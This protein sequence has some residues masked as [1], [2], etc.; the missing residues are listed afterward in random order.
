MS[1]REYERYDDRQSDY[2]RRGGR[3][4]RDT[5][6][7]DYRQ[8][9]YDGPGPSQRTQTQVKERESDTIITQGNRTERGPRQPDFL[10]EDYGRNDNA[11][12]LVV[13]DDRREEDYVSRSGGRS[14]GPPQGERVEREE[15]VYRERDRSRGPPQPPYPR[16]EVGDD[17]IVFRERARSRPPPAREEIDISIREKETDRRPPPP[18]VY[19]PPPEQL[20]KKEEVTYTRERSRSRQPPPPRRD[21]EEIDIDIKERDSYNRG[22]DVRREDI[23]IDIKEQD[24]SRGREVRKEDID[25]DIDIRNRGGPAPRPRSVSRGA[26]VRKDREEWIVRKPRT[27]SPSPSP[28]PPARDY[29]KEQIVIRT[30]TPEPEPPPREPSPEPLPPPEPPVYRPPIIQEVITHHRHIDHGVE[31]VR[32][33]TPPP[34][35]PPPKKEEENIDIQINRSGVRNGKPY[36]E[37]IDID[38]DIKDREGKGRELDRRRSASARPPSRVYEDNTYAEADYYNRRVGSR[39]YNGEAYNG[40]TRNWG[41]M[42]VPP[43]TERI[44]MDGA[45]GGREEVTWNRYDGNRHERFYTGD[46]VY[47]SGYG[48]GSPAPLSPPPRDDYRETRF[49]EARIERDTHWGRKRDKK[50]TEVTKDL[51]IEE[52]IKEMGYEYEESDSYFY[53]ME[54]LRYV[55]FLTRLDSS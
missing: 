50:W 40:A 2:Y 52:A 53:V 5:E 41:L 35:P 48:N 37:T 14:R 43:G 27:P 46:R 12:Q 36:D 1:R 26:L 55:S 34:A 8:S 21:R 20:V 33:P 19:E 25:I 29:E 38:V 13:R 51:V 28:P 39:G 31:R 7:V 47:D 9:R 45:G 11:G 42:D 4:E 16:S 10:R 49:S 6:E 23:D 54:Y 15:I 24:R 32:S 3:T 30:R 17:E 18:R 44:R 22:R